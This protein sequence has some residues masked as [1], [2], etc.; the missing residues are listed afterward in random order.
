MRKLTTGEKSIFTSVRLTQTQK[1]QLETTARKSG[2]TPSEI[3]RRGVTVM[4]LAIGAGVQ[5][6]K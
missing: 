2:L 3:I 1:A 5:P 4:A 6:A